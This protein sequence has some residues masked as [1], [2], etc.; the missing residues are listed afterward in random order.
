MNIIFPQ[1][2][3]VIPAYNAEKYIE[4]TIES[5]LTQT[6]ADCEIVLVDDGSTDKT[7]E[8]IERYTAHPN[9]H[10][11]GY[12]VNRGAPH[13]YNHGILHSRGRYVMFLDSDDVL[14]PEYAQCV[15]QDIEASGSD[16]GFSNLYALD[17]RN[18]TDKTLYGAP[19]YPAY[20]F[21]FGGSDRV[22]PRSSSELRKMILQAVHISP[23]AIYHRS[24]FRDFGLEDH[25]L[26]ISHDWLRHIRF[27]INGARCTYLDRPLGYYRFHPEGNSQKNQLDNIVEVIK[28]LEIVLSEM[29][30]L[31]SEEEK[32]I[33]QLNLRAWR[34][35][36][37]GVLAN[38]DLTTAQIINLLI[39]KR[40]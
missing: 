3:I 40:F 30:P 27:I 12:G 22:F 16:M 10:A 28:V 34:K 13:A 6:L 39:E 38:S 11:F 7:S 14:L 24:L 23:R 2:S 4:E 1:L 18:Q 32:Q 15:I 19:R 21:A 33:A 20:E 5:A 17:G 36:I 29:T 8:I 25:R 26:R 9:V 31:L 35:N 37:F